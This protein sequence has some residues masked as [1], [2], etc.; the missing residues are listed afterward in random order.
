MKWRDKGA[1]KRI[2]PK[3]TKGKPNG[4]YRKKKKEREQTSPPTKAQSSKSKE[5]PSNNSL[6]KTEA[7]WVPSDQLTMRGKKK[8]KRHRQKTPQPTRAQ[9]KKTNEAKTGEKKEGM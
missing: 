4:P 1:T 6:D 7:F 9:T 5:K 2:T 8:T 3:N